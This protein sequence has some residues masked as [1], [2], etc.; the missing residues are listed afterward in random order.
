MTPL[1]RRMLEDMQV[2]NLSPNTQK[3]YVH[4]VSLFARHFRGSPESL[5][6]QEVRSYQVH[7]T[8]EKK[9]SPASIAV[10]PGVL[11]FLYTA[12]LSKRWNVEAVLP[13]PQQ[14]KTRLSKKR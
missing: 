6:P 10:A 8:N 4:Q 14:A 12:T 2:H 9:L 7:L 1:R 5:G 11:Q 13:M 3:C